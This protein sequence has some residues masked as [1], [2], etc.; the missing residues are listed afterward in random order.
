MAEPSG[1][2]VDVV[3]I[4]KEIRESIQKKRAQG[5]YTRAFYSFHPEVG[6]VYVAGGALDHLIRAHLLATLLL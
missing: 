1:A 4:M 5:V 3:A 2:P 6:D